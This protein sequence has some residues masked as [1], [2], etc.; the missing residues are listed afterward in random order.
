MSKH[1][2][3]IINRDIIAIIATMPENLEFEP[4]QGQMIFSSSPECPKLLCS[5]SRLLFTGYQV[6][7]PCGK[8]AGAGHWPLNP[9]LVPRLRTSRATLLLALYAF[10]VGTD[11]ILLYIHIILDTSHWPMELMEDPVRCN[12]IPA[13][14]LL[15]SSILPAVRTRHETKHWGVLEKYV[16]RCPSSLTPENLYN[17]LHE[18][19]HVFLHATSAL[20]SIF[21]FYRKKNIPN[22]S[23]TKQ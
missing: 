1:P 20:L 5:P 7:V 23:P 11:K 19:V 13:K 4:R 14:C 12:L 17:T 18:Q 6:F 8:K 9:H 10:R 22:K 3:N 16:E 15:K 21:I 2:C